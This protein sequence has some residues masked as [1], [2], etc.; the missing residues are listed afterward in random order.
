MQ[1][2]IVLV[3]IRFENTHSENT[4]H[5]LQFLIIVGTIYNVLGMLIEKSIMIFVIGHLYKCFMLYM[6]F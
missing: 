4:L 5:E 2:E 6:N 3:F 1:D